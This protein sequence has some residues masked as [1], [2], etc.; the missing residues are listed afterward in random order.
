MDIFRI[1]ELAGAAVAIAE[2]VY[3]MVKGKKQGAETLQHAQKAKEALKRGHD[4]A[5]EAAAELE[6]IA[7]LY[8]K[9]GRPR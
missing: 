8:K 5:A 3:T 6:R 9:Y 7:E 2:R 4:G 1:L